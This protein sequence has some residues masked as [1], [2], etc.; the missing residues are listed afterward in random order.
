MRWFARAGAASVFALVL[1]A[2]GPALEVVRPLVS[3]SDGGTPLPPGFTHVPGETLFFTFEMTGYQKSPEEKI[4]LNYTVDAFDPRGVRIVETVT[5]SIAA[6]LT[7]QDKEWRPKVR[8][9]IALPPLADSGTYKIAVHV[10]D[11]IAHTAADKAVAVEV[12]GHEVAPSDSL[13]IRN[14]RFFRGEDDHEAL[15]Q[16]TYRPGDP[17][18][19]RFDITGYRFGPK[20]AID[21]AYGI[22]IVTAAG[23]TLWS[24]PE[25]AVERADSFYPK[26]YVP[27]TM[28]INLQSTIRPGVYT[29]RVQAKDAIGQQ[30]FEA[31]YNFTV[32]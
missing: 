28:S 1:S 11:E 6:E 2:A 3:Q 23:R 22:A 16:P 24:Q 7:P 31:K 26:R 4:Q 32:E 10:T 21:V 15:A 25:A 19:A 20:N 30:D 29:I 14:F 9:E 18:W 5:N 17:V 8:L 13:A 27:G 12:R